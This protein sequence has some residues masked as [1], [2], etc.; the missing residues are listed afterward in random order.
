MEFYET[1]M[2]KKFFKSQLPRLIAALE[3][4]GN[5]LENENPPFFIPETLCLWVDPKGHPRRTDR[6]S[7]KNC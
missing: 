7:Q 4:I 2:G 6:R 3:Q 5:A 1:K